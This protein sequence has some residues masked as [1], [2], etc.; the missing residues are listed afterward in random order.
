MEIHSLTWLTVALNTNLKVWKSKE[1]PQ[2]RILGIASLMMKI[3][4]AERF[5]TTV[6]S[7]KASLLTRECSLIKRKQRS[8]RVRRKKAN[9]SRWL[10]KHTKIYPIVMRLRLILYFHLQARGSLSSWLR[11]PKSSKTN[12][13]QGAWSSGLAVSWTRFTGVFTRQQESSLVASSSTT[14]PSRS[15]QLHLCCKWEL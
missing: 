15:W 11:L 9:C 10:K 3:S 8:S 7:L 14:L 5:Q 12:G 2:T 13:F 6:S 1:Q 4:L